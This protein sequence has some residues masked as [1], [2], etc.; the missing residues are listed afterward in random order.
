MRSQQAGDVVAFVLP[1]NVDDVTEPSGGNTYDRRMC[2]SLPGVG[3]PVLQVAVRGSW[4][5]PGPTG[6]ARLARALAALPDHTTVLVDGLVACGV[7]DVVVPHARRLRL[8]VLVHLPLADETGLDPVHAA[9]LDACE[10]AT[11][12]AVRQVV[13]TSPTAAR[14]LVRRHRLAPSTVE[15]VEPGVDLAPLA[16][17]TDGVSRLL[18][19]AAV[20]PRKGQDVLVEALAKLRDLPLTVD[21]VGSLTRAPEYVDE[22]RWSVRRLG[23][24][25]RVTFSGP[26]AGAELD[27]AYDGADLVLLPSHAETYGMVVTEALARG[28]PVVASDVGG[29]SDALGRSADGTAPGLL[30]P[31][32][33]AGALA[34]A[35]RRWATDAGLRRDLRTAA[36]DRG[37]ALEEWD[38]AAR[39]LTEVV[40]RWRSVPIKVA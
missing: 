31:S 39:R 32:G 19:V 33:D 9:E 14:A 8:G 36:L 22:L 37:N 27:A 12:R 6:R 28:I 25:D 4:P 10:R 21:F 7:P 23:L 18:C 24:G 13:A 29:V 5:E 30:V 40:A 2:E 38:G 1:G 20:T 35:L 17:G 15:V 16:S 11:L 26:K 34:A 3:L